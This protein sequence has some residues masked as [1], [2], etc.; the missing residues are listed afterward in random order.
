VLA[1]LALGF[2]ALGSSIRPNPDND[3]A[4]PDPVTLDVPTNLQDPAG[5]NFL[6][7]VQWLEIHDNGVEGKNSLKHAFASKTDL[8]RLTPGNIRAVVTLFFHRLVEKDVPVQLS[9]ALP[10]GATLDSW[11]GAPD[12][13]D[14]KCVPHKREIDS[15]PL[16]PARI[17]QDSSPRAP[18]RSGQYVQC[19]GSPKPH[20]DYFTFYM[21]RR[22][23]ETGISFATTRTRAKV[24]EPQISLR[25]VG[26]E[27]PVG[28]TTVAA[29]ADADQL[30]WSVPPVIDDPSAV[31]WDYDASPSARGLTGPK[32]GVRER[33]IHD[34]ADSNFWAGLWLGGAGGAVV[35][36]VQTVPCMKPSPTTG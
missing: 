33:V 8:P 10:I 35:A 23:A 9:I 5:D 12:A 17:H 25:L 27:H 32:T 29:I 3:L 30:S 14:V 22:G 16:E 31:G 15:G 4:L 2:F 18:G 11:G 13:G 7:N 1:I 26:S 34:D 28:A 36:F 19:E 21:D 24:Q 6:T 20:D